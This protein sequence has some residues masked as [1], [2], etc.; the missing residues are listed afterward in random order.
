MPKKLTLRTPQKGDK[1]Q[2]LGKKKL[3]LLSKLFSDAKLEHQQRCSFPLI[4]ASE[5]I[6]YLP[7]L[8]RGEFTRVK[9]GQD[10]VGISYERI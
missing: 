4:C 9:E 1:M 10:F 7:G 5:E 3:T 6:I 2:I 8:R